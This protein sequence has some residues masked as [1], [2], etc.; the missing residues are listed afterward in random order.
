MENTTKA[1]VVSENGGL[2]MSKMSAKAQEAL[3]NLALAL[4]ENKDSNTIRIIC[5]HKD[6]LTFAQQEWL[7]LILKNYV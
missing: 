7:Q 5:N 2:I 6:S 1:S 4:P 3:M